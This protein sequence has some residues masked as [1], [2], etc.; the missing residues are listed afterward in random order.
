MK[1]FLG[2]DLTLNKNNQ[3][4]N[5]REFLSA[6]PSPALEQAL[7]KSAGKAEATTE[8]AKLP[9]SLRMV[10]FFCGVLSL[11]LLSGMLKADVTFAQG[12]QN[13]PWLYWTA[14]FSAA[15]WATLKVMGIKKSKSV[16]GTEENSQVFA[17]FE[18]IAD[19]IYTELGVPA[20]ARDVDILFFFYRIKDGELRLVERAIATQYFNPIFRASA[21]DENLYL[22]SLD[23]KYAFPLADI[24]GI[25]TVK[26][27]IR[28]A[29]W[30]KEEKYDRGIYKPFKITADNY[31]C[32][33][34]KSYHILEI[35][36]DGETWGIY[37]PCYELPVFEELTGLKATEEI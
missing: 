27:H 4:P 35:N 18:S 30:N 20:D 7:R 22:T 28:I 17:S 10:Q 13:A 5:G 37:I 3:L 25:R 11:L 33:H 29:A 26:K 8:K 1:P 32:I 9:K 16:L 31:G 15:I 21:D 34:C 24:T 19:S 2:I 23:G 6:V 36:R 14:G 12:Y